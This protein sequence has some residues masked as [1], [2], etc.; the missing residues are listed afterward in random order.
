METLKMA[1]EKLSAAGFEPWYFNTMGQNPESGNARGIIKWSIESIVA[2]A[3]KHGAAEIQL[4]RGGKY[5]TLGYTFYNENFRYSSLPNA[6]S[7]VVYK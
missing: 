3:S 1:L 2:L 4:R 7:A 5:Y 6:L